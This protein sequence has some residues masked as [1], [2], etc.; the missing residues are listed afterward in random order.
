MSRKGRE[1][2]VGEWY[3]IGRG[4]NAYEKAIFD[5]VHKIC[6]AKNGVFQTEEYRDCEY[7]EDEYE[8]ERYEFYHM[9][10]DKC[11][12]RDALIE[13][14]YKRRRA[15]MK[16]DKQLVSKIEALDDE[17][18]ISYHDGKYGERH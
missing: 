3:E 12:E 2:K 6:M 7:A 9:P 16:K 11:E 5:D 15:Y 17:L 18:N 4:T 14:I 10:K 13:E 8:I 1:I